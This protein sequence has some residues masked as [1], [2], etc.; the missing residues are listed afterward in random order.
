MKKRNVFKICA[1]VLV[2]LLVLGMVAPALVYAFASDEGTQTQA[3]E[4][5]RIPLLVII[6]NFDANGNGQNDFDP[7]KSDK[8]FA[9]A[10]S[11]EFGEQWAKTT[12]EYWND[13]IFGSG[14]GSVADYF[15]ELSCGKIKYVP[16]A[17][18]NKEDAGTSIDGVISVNIKSKHPSAYKLSNPAMYKIYRIRMVDDA[19]SEAL[20]YMNLYSFDK[21]GDKKISSSELSVIVINPGCDEANVTSEMQIADDIHFSSVTELCSRKFNYQTIAVDPGEK[22]NVASISEYSSPDVPASVGDVAYMLMRI[23]GAADI[24][25]N[26]AEG[27][28]TAPVA[29]WPL[30]YNLSL[31]CDGYKLNGGRTPSY[32]D[33]YSRIKAGISQE[34]EIG[35]DGE[36]TLY[37]TKSGKYNILRIPTIDP[38]EYFL[39]ELRVKEGFDE[40]VSSGISGG[41]MMV[42]HIDEGINSSYYKDG[43]SCTSVSKD[44]KRHDPGIVPL[45][46]TG[47]NALG[48]RLETVSADDLFYYLSGEKSTSV[49]N[50]SSFSG[51]DSE[52]ISLNSYPNGWDGKKGYNVS[53]E[54]LSETEDSIRIKI[55]RTDY[56]YLPMLTAKCLSFGKNS[57][58]VEGNIFREFGEG[59]ESCG[60]ILS[61]E[62]DPTEEN[63]K[64]LSA[65][66]SKNGSFYTVFE[67][68]TPGTKYYFKAFAKTNSGTGYSGVGSAMTEL[69]GEYYV[70]RMYRNITAGEEPVEIK[71]L[72]GSQ[73]S[74]SFEMKKEGYRFVGW[75]TDA[76]LTKQFDMSTVITDASA[77]ITLYAKW[78]KEAETT[79]TTTPVQTTTTT[80]TVPPQTTTSAVPVQTTT[81]ASPATTT[82]ASGPLQTTTTAS[83]PLQTTTTP[84]SVAPVTTTGNPSAPTDTGNKNTLIIALCIVIIV[85]CA[86]FITALGFMRAKRRS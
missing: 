40:Y 47:W 8:L 84:A 81:S 66:M 82:T 48:N 73:I 45:V 35:D 46:R 27:G 10:K 12:P 4:Q 3:Q 28:R 21:D 74:Y 34:T 61:K 6:M 29:G 69:S 16:A 50:S 25:N 71:C 85:L 38:E 9:D 57:V 72:L 5:K 13:I 39:V 78:E 11:A 44:E 7:A 33:P 83:E 17:I 76:E 2:S 37:S 52:S 18:E 43:G 23:M 26:T 1:I 67:G 58:T 59:I 15:D 63:G 86:A 22:N 62:S 20:K 32:A 51:A 41:G 53:I 54:I 60:V 36:Y 65:V 68:L 24:G 55:S 56:T 64:V 79:Q 75:F 31:L 49:F 42:W 30:A 70:C 77:N 14:A 19:I 80:V